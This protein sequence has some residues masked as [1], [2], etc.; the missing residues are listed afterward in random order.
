MSLRE[1]V[2]TFTFVILLL[3]VAYL[4]TGLIFPAG[5]EY[6]IGEGSSQLIRAFLPAYSICVAI[7]SFGVL[8]LLL[9]ELVVMRAKNR[10]TLTYLSLFS[11]CI[12]V[13]VMSSNPICLLYVDD[14]YIASCISHMVLPWAL[15]FFILYLFASLG[16]QYPKWMRLL[17]FL[18]YLYSVIC[19]IL[20]VGGIFSFATTGALTQL[21][22]LALGIDIVVRSV[23]SF[24]TNGF[25][26]KESVTILAINDL[27]LVFAAIVDVIR[28][29]V[30]HVTDVSRDFRFATLMF[31][32]VIGIDAIMIYADEQHLIEGAGVIK[33]MAVHDGLTGVY[34]RMAFN[35]K[36]ETLPMSEN[37]GFI[38][39]DI[40]NLK[41][42]N[43]NY[44]HAEGDALIKSI[45][46]GIEKA[47]S[48]MGETYRYGG[49][50]FTVITDCFDEDKIKNCLGNLRI[51]LAL[52]NRED[53]VHVPMAMACG[54]DR[55]QKGDESIFKAFERADEKM[56][57]NKRGMKE[58][59]ARLGRK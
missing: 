34:N 15:G 19:V 13:W 5:A 42:A 28:V 8:F 31:M 37:I 33:S 7:L 56:Y 54:Y 51:Y 36:L 3:V 40:N 58:L 6:Q 11:A 2:N 17:F 22:A 14:E 21:F 18:P 45:A 59:E 10:R 16:E 52:M 48:D 26:P 12:A 46:H 24:V 9:S 23:L 41:E 20:D 32:F 39:F 44:G 27:M 55:F 25:S 57:E 38:H 29:L 53:V 4:A 43:D 1:K 49:D 30:F 47:F 50:E 35:S